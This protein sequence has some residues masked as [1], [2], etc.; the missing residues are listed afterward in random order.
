[1][2]IGV[3]M[4]LTAVAAV[5]LFSYVSNESRA[6]SESVAAAADHP[7]A[8]LYRGFGCFK[9]HGQNLQG[10]H[11]A[12]PLLDTASHWKRDELVSFMMKPGE[13]PK[14]QRLEQMAV[15]YN[16]ITMPSWPAPRDRLE[17]VVDYL[18]EASR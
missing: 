4:A 6:P 3:G 7:G 1:M 12:P 16:P 9:C 2:L 13:Y 14:D 17:T 5:M 8:K 15:R 10:T 18:M 11:K